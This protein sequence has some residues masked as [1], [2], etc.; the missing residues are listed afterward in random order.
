M[1][2]IRHATSYKMSDAC[3]LRAVLHPR[4]FAA[5]Q[6]VGSIASGLLLGHFVAQ[7]LRLETSEACISTAR[8]LLRVV[9]AMIAPC[10]VKTYG[11]YVRREL[12][13]L[14]AAEESR[15]INAKLFFATL[16]RTASD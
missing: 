12:T 4:I 10:S 3:A 9:A 11:K 14:T 8:V 1:L 13:M 2:T 7:R 15:Q 16:D 6:N 5:F